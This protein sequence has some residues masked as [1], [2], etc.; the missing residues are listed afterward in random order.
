MEGR[1]RCRARSRCVACTAASTWGPG[2]K[3]VSEESE[4][5][6]APRKQWRTGVL[7]DLGL[8]EHDGHVAAHSARTADVE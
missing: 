5:Q 2:T 8:H 3:N 4:A 7:G 1:P 6:R